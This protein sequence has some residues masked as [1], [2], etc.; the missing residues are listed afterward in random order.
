[1]ALSERDRRY[2]ADPQ[3]L[4]GSTII[5]PT[6]EVIAGPAGTDDEVIYADAD[7]AQMVRAKLVHDTAGHYQ[8]MDVFS[9]D[10][11]PSEPPVGAVADG[12]AAPVA[13]P[14]PRGTQDG[15]AG[16]GSARADGRPA[17]E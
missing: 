9:F 6:G 1:M 4:G 14:A 16:H 11:H 17:S 10:V 15:A 12:A 3:T 8:R 5:A 13:R 7:L 2:L